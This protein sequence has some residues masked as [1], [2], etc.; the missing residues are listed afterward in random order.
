MIIGILVLG[1][2][3][4]GVTEADLLPG[5]D[6]NWQRYQS[7]NFELF[8]HQKDR[9]SREI[10]H[11]LELLRAVFLDHFKFVERD[12]LDVTVFS[13]SRESHMKAYSPMHEGRTKEI[14][15]LYVG[16]PDR[17][18]I[19]LGPSQNSDDARQV[20]FHEYVHHL[21][22]AVGMDPPLWFN[23][24]MAELM[25]GI[26]VEKGKVVF[27]QPLAGRLGPLQ[28][29]R[30]IPLGELF[31]VGQHSKYYQSKD[32]AGLFYAQSW[33]LLHYWLYGQS[34]L[35]PE[36]VT[37]FLK[38][39]IDREVMAKTNTKSLFEECFKMDYEAM[40]KQL[41][42]YVK[43][44]RYYFGGVPTPEIAATDTYSSTKVSTDIIRKRLAE[45]A[46]RVHGS[47]TGKLVLLQATAEQPVDSRVYE[48][49]G[50][51][52]WMEGDIDSAESYWA[53]AVEAGST[54]S[55]VLRRLA[56][57]EWGTWFNHFNYDLKLPDEVA[58][59]YREL[60]VR[61]IN[62]EPE[63]EAAYEMLVWVE[64]FASKPVLENVNV[65]Q[66]RFGKL[67]DKNRTLL[68]LALFRARR[69][70]TDEA[71]KLVRLLG[72]TQMDDWTKR[73]AEITLARLEGKE[74]GEVSLGSDEPKKSD[75]VARLTKNLLKIPSVPVPEDL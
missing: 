17:A 54:N 18:V 53:R 72:K 46:V 23:E 66:T 49:L 4:R 14:A 24:G 8:S 2:D 75:Q 34:K 74:V 64:T 33:A 5:I 43:R 16:R 30:L 37:K 71:I 73:T 26:K 21:F 7:A 22:K 41:Q 1:G 48:V 13:F 12:R 44:G 60:L 31:D 65:V 38:L 39:V 55:A 10:L 58:T 40:S 25:S 28:Q 35:E 59:R 68:G 45:L 42:R 50:A 51:D 69:G 32:H 20:V 70:M 67:K 11:D 15:G 63:Q 29:S 61:S 62:S 36:Q 47:A 3:C 9:E 27:G 6:D 52:A 19:M 56:Q 57:L